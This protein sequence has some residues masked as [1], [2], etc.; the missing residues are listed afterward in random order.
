MRNNKQEK[1][2]T[3]LGAAKSHNIAEKPEHVCQSKESQEYSDL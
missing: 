1:H 3:A 2:F